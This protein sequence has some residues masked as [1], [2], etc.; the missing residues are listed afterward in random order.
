MRDARYSW[1][2]D[3]RAGYSL[4][5]LVLTLA[6]L[7][8]ASAIAMPRYAASMDRYRADAAAQRVVA[9]LGHAR[10]RALAVSGIR[11]VVFDPALDQYAILE[12]VD[13]DDGTGS[14]TVDLRGNPYGGAVDTV[15]L[16]DPLD[17]AD[18]VLTVIFDAYGNP[19]SGGT[20]VLHV[21]GSTRT[22]VLD[23]IGKAVVQ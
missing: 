23:E 8:V 5:E 4:L 21:G 22:V 9:D 10:T 13:I 11:T 1:W 20:I 15:S 16:D 19:D 6:I 18:D 14:Y 12:D 7:A 2:R 3:A 17:G